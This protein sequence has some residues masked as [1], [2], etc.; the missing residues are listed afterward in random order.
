MKTSTFYILK[1]STFY[2]LNFFATCLLII[3]LYLNFMH[4]EEN[5]ISLVSSQKETTVSRVQPTQ[6]TQPGLQEGSKS[7]V[8]GK[9]A[10]L[11]IEN[12]LKESSS[13]Q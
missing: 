9:T 13:S 7:Y 11:P 2:L 8:A 6:S 10:S 12:K 5:L 1:T 4:K 3:A